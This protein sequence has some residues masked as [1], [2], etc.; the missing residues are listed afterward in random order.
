MSTPNGC[1]SNDLDYSSHLKKGLRTEANEKAIT[2]KDENERAGRGSNCGISMLS[3]F[4][5]GSRSQQKKKSQSE[6]IV[7]S[8]C[9]L[10][11]R[12]I[13]PFAFLTRNIAKHYPG[14]YRA[15]D[16]SHSLWP[17]VPTTPKNRF[18]REA[19]PAS[20]RVSRSA[21]DRPAEPKSSSY[22]CPLDILFR[23]A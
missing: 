8:D 10:V 2:M 13:G 7:R 20:E 22:V 12:L 18:V 3:H 19:N 1:V 11:Q 17:S 14:T 21:R 6:A 16:D 23:A 5:G 4:V 9:L 15:C